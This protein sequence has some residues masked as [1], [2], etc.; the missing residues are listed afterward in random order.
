MEREGLS[1]SAR[2]QSEYVG[3]HFAVQVPTDVF[4]EV[5][6]TL[7][8]RGVEFLID[9]TLREEDRCWAAF[10]LDPDGNIIELTDLRATAG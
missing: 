3:G 7:R 8:E 6:V 10:I 2:E 4:Q 9:P 5:A 1:E